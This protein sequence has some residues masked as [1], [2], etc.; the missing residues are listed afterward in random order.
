MSIFQH[1]PKVQPWTGPLPGPGPNYIPQHPLLRQEF[2][3]AEDS[4]FEDAMSA[5]VNISTKLAMVA[6]RAACK[7]LKLPQGDVFVKWLHKTFSGGVCVIT[8]K[9]HLGFAL[10]KFQRKL[11]WILRELRK[12]LPQK[13][14]KRKIL[15]N[16]QSLMGCERGSCQNSILKKGIRLMKKKIALTNEEVQKWA[17]ASAKKLNQ[18]DLTSWM[19]AQVPIDIT[20]S[21]KGECSFNQSRLDAIADLGI[22]NIHKK[23]IQQLIQKFNKGLAS[24]HIVHDTELT[25]KEL[26]KNL[27]IVYIVKKIIRIFVK[28]NLD[29]YFKTIKEAKIPKE[30]LQKWIGE[31]LYNWNTNWAG[32]SDNLSW[33]D[34]KERQI[35]YDGWKGDH[36]SCNL[37]AAVW[38]DSA[39]GD[40]PNLINEI[41]SVIQM[42]LDKRDPLYRGRQNK[43]RLQINLVGK[44]DFPFNSQYGI[45][46]DKKRKENIQKFF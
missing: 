30:K 45:I 44:T 21:P 41:N 15:K 38:V 12:K 39:A 3:P 34:T 32:G 20:P 7:K 18:A 22:K 16:G 29:Q 33:F 13:D 1:I 25:S 46:K 27:Q 19:N 17:K 14:A 24:S 43:D 11:V 8:E 35:Q 4:M 26:E 31:A 37:S 28:K 6:L 40:S 36:K 9:S 10:Q 2:E 42:E 5:T 23:E